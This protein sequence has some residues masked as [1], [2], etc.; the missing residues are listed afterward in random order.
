MG[1]PVQIWV[2]AS[3]F[4]DA[5]ARDLA[6]SFRR[7]QVNHKFL[8]ASY[9]QAAKWLELH[10]AYSPARN[11]PDC[12]ATYDRAFGEIARAVGEKAVSLI[13]LGCGGGQKDGRLWDTLHDAI[14]TPVDVSVPLVVT[15]AH[16]VRKATH[17]VVC[18]LATV[19]DLE[20]LLPKHTARLFTFFGMLPN[21]EPGMILPKLATW[22]RAEDVIL[23]SANLTPSGGIE[24]VLPQYANALTEDWL[25]A[26][27]EDFG[28]RSGRIEWRI[29]DRI[30]ADF[31]FAEPARLQGI[32]F[33]PG[34]KLRLFFS[35]RYR[36][37]ELHYTFAHYGLE[38]DDQWITA[39]GEE[40]V[41]MCHKG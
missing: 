40:A 20:P 13:G 36:L 16:R 38:V 6:E 14:Y 39:S 7:R 24:K 11:D 32:E 10:E 34:E 23:L 26:F 1:E 4:P 37:E 5:V 28:V 22:A 8:Y 19:V 18:D 41:F 33:R 29:E 35:F 25:R 15:A 9:R 3:Q 30:R 31:V 17:G 27:L 21:F 12:L 2:D